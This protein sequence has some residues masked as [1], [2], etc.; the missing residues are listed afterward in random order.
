MNARIVIYAVWKLLNGSRTGLIESLSTYDHT[1]ELQSS[2]CS[3]YR[4]IRVTIV[5]PI[6]ACL[7]SKLCCT[8]A[9][10][11]SLNFFDDSTFEASSHFCTATYT[12]RS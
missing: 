3:S 9:T 7:N 1:Y 2:Q 5:W 11:L 10:T 4:T 12:V 8:D 6:K